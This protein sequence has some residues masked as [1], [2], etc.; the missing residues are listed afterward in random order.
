[1]LYF[2]AQH[3][4]LS[5]LGDSLLCFGSAGASPPAPRLLQ[6]YRALQWLFVDDA[7]SSIIFFPLS[8]MIILLIRNILVYWKHS[9]TNSHTWEGQPVFILIFSFNFYFFPPGEH[10]GTQITAGTSAQVPS[11]GAGHFLLSKPC[12]ECLPTEKRISKPLFCLRSA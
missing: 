4:Y 9:T 11:R 10:G 1:M 3:S 5:V 7:S 8:K 12:P 6:R 2:C